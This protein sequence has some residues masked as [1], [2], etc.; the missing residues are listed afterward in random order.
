MSYGV[1]H[2]PCPRFSDAELTA[3]QRRDY[4][5]FYKNYKEKLRFKKKRKKTWTWPRKKERKQDLDLEIK[6]RRKELEQ[7]NKKV[8][9]SYFF[10]LINSHIRKHWSSR[11][12]RE[13]IAMRHYVDRL[14]VTRTWKRGREEVGY[15]DIPTSSKKSEQSMK[16]F[17][18]KRFLTPRRDG[19][20]WNSKKQA[21]AA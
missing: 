13:V 17:L 11:K 20:I 21:E 7:E 15:R 9:R 4:K 10:P 2:V 1:F 18:W 16:V 5:R 8:L 19:E 6:E 3:D 14:Q 12:S